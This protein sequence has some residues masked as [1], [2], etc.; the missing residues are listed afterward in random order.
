MKIKNC[1]FI[2]VFMAFALT[3]TAM[4]IYAAPIIFD[5]EVA[6]VLNPIIEGSNITIENGTVYN[7][8]SDTAASTILE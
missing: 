3:M 5:E 6:M 4:P 2:A 7:L 8:T 1:T